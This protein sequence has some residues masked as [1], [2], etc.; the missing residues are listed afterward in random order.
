VSYL[1][2]RLVADVVSGARAETVVHRTFAE[3]VLRLPPAA[4][5][6]GR[7]L[8]VYSP[9]HSFSALTLY[10][11]DALLA[12]W[13]FLMLVALDQ[14]LGGAGGTIAPAA[15]IAWM[16]STVLSKLR[17]KLGQRSIAERA[18]IDP[19]FLI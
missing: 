6:L 17:E 13:E 9:H 11:M 10:G 1:L 18:L 12:C 15:A 3:H 8:F 4:A 14:A 19:R 2:R 7:S 5:G 16:L